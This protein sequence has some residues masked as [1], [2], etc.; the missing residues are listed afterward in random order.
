MLKVLEA[1]SIWM[2]G[3]ALLKCPHLHR[4]YLLKVPFILILSAFSCTDDKWISFSEKIITHELYENT[5][6]KYDVA[7]VKLQK[8]VDISTEYV[9][10]I[11]INLAPTKGK[12]Y[13]DNVGV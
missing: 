13:T 3:F 10:P 4:T 12:W 5:K 9:T 6:I 2:I 1:G 11:A 8:E 7:L